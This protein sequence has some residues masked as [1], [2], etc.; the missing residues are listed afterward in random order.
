MAEESGAAASADDQDAQRREWAAVLQEMRLDK[1]AQSDAAEKEEHANFMADGFQW[2]EQRFGS[3]TREMRQA[4]NWSQEDLASR[5]SEVGVEMHQTTVAKLERG[6]R[7]LRVSEAVAIATAMGEPVLSVFYGPGPEQEPMSI[8]M[9]RESLER[10]EEA[11]AFAKETLASHYESLT[12]YETERLMT[13]R[14]IQ[15]AAAKADRGQHP[16]A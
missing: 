1:M 13:A 9:L 8:K 3:K 12:F 6:A 15:Q 2:W 7:P 14:A 11:I 4:R 10:T 5:L 16:E